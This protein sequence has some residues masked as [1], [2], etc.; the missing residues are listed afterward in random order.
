MQKFTEADLRAA[1]GEALVQ[2]AELQSNPPALLVEGEQLIKCLESNKGLSKLVAAKDAL[3]ED[4]AKEITQANER[5]KGLADALAEQ[6]ETIKVQSKEIT[7]LTAEL[8][9]ANESYVQAQTQIR[10]LQQ[11]IKAQK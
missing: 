1:L 11:Q 7:A 8:T 9:A 3:I 5:N 10:L 2:V 4:R 6:R